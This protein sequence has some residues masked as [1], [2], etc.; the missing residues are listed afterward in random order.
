M[1][2]NIAQNGGTILLR[3]DGSDIQY[4][5]EGSNVWT[6]ISVF[7]IWITNSSPS[8][9]NILTVKLTT[10]ITINDLN[11][12]FRCASTYIT[13]D[14]QNYKWTFNDVLG[15][16]G[17]I[18]NG[19]GGYPSFSN[20]II[21][22][23]ST[24][25]TGTTTLSDYCGWLCKVHYGSGNTTNNLEI[26]NCK[27]YATIINGG[28]GFC[29]ALLCS[30]GGSITIND[31]E[32]FA[33]VS[34]AGLA[35]QDTGHNGGII[36]VNNFRNSGVV[37]GGGGLISVA[38][39]KCK[40]TINN[41]SNT[42]EIHGGSGILSYSLGAEPMSGWIRF[43][44]C[45]NTGDIR[46]GGGIIG[47]FSLGDITISKCYNTGNLIGIGACGGIAGKEI[48]IASP[49][50]TVPTS[51]IVISECYNTGTIGNNCA[52]ILA[53]RSCDGG[54]YR[55]ENT[56]TISDCYST[57]TINSGG[58]GIC[59]NYSG[60]NNAIL[61]ITNCYSSGNI[62]SN[63][64][65]II[66]TYSGTNQNRDGYGIVNINNC[67][68]RGTISS[69]SGG[70]CGQYAAVD[71]N[72]SVTVSNCY[73][74]G[75]ISGVNPIGIFG[76]NKGSAASFSN[77]YVAN[78]SW[79]DSDANANLTGVP[80]STPGVG[81]IWASVDSANS[82]YILLSIAM[83]LFPKVDTVLSNFNNLSKEIGETFDITDPSSNSPAPFVY[84][85]S[86]TSVA[87][88]GTAITEQPIIPNNYGTVT[89]NEITMA[90]AVSGDGNTIVIAHYNNS[91]ISYS[92]YNG[93]SWSSY[94][95]INNTQPF[96]GIYYGCCL[97]SD[98]LRGIITSTGGYCYFFT[99]DGTAYSSIT[100]TLDTTV[101]GYN[102]VG[103]TSDGS[104]IVAVA[105]GQVYFATWNGT[106]YDAFISTGLTLSPS[107]GVCITSDGSKIAYC[108][109]TNLVYWA[110][111]NGTNYV[112]PIKINGAS[113]SGRRLRFMNNGNMLVYAPYYAPPQ[114]SLFVD[115]INNY[116][117]FVGLPTIPYGEDPWGFAVSST[118]VYMLVSSPVNTIKSWTISNI[119]NLIDSSRQIKV[120]G[121]GSAT[122]TATQN[123]TIGFKQ[124]SIS[125]LLTVVK[126]N[127]RLISID[128]NVVGGNDQFKFIST[129]NVPF[130]Y[131]FSDTSVVQLNGNGTFSFLN[132]CSVLVT[133]HQ[134]ESNDY[135]SGDF[136]SVI[137]YNKLD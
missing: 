36:V 33:P 7:P 35:T 67:Y 49:W 25:A 90:F 19:G 26:N 52:G 46:S 18:Q 50:A 47:N 135:F 70:I 114:Y 94:V 22:N 129:S 134:D 15:Y 107:Q 113:N 13:F 102:D 104:R 108:D 53:E 66:G 86:N 92:K 1:S 31:C 40:I 57:G 24:Y 44:N 99:W 124:G 111:W 123:E 23:M 116:N 5:S 56:I 59:G 77:C 64:G 87:R 8:S 128:S 132:N 73:S 122:I 75:L 112:N 14:G 74:S 82:P 76:N 61:T 136:T 84:T 9:S 41:C 28:G 65:G 62:G 120:V 89:I 34:G 80:S 30:G 127:P 81:T 29:G 126:G 85:S 133:A 96:S 42:G 68:S 115:S 119:N 131:T 125:F 79:S 110:S 58:S 17:L 55:R 69:S 48:G 12:S 43:T 78:N 71:S 10:D 51:N 37:F 118:S 11:F 63:G 101:R 100:R 45:Y 97:T 21:K 39:T 83:K 117:S 106:N 88:F 3:Q 130:S 109:N 137:S 6:T 4:S 54:R 60:S 93:S 16:T 95:T 105:D 98:G 91:S 72:S 20:V 27:N 103:V 121:S 2:T 38:G 32:N